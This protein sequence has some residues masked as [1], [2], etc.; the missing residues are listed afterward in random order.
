VQTLVQPQADLVARLR[1][2]GIKPPPSVV[3]TYEISKQ[4][5][6]T[7]GGQH[8]YI[9]ET[10]QPIQLTAHQRLVLNIIAG[11]HQ[12]ERLLPFYST[13]L[14]SDIKKTG[15]TA[16][17]GLYA[18][19]RAE[20]GLQKKEIQFFAND[21]E[22]SRGRGYA[23]LRLSIELHPLY[24][25]R[26]RVLLDNTGSVR[27]RIIDDFMEHVP[28]GTLVKA[29]NVDY[30][31]DAGS[32]PDLSVWTEAWGFDSKKQELLYDEMTPI[33]TK[34]RS[35][36]YVES[37]AGY[38][39]KSIVLEKLWNLATDEGQGARRLTHEDLNYE[40]P[41]PD[42]E[43]LPLWVNDEAGVF[44]YI[45]QGP[46]AKLRVPWTQGPAA[47]Q[48]YT[49]QAHTLTVEQNDRLHGNYWVTPTSAFLP[50]EWWKACKDES[51]PS[52]LPYREPVHMLVC[53]ALDE[54]IKVPDP[55]Q[56]GVLLDVP[57]WTQYIHPYNWR[58]TGAPA[59]SIVC[60]ADASVSGDCTAF[61]G[62]TRHPQRYQ[63][64]AL[65][66]SYKWDPPRGGKLD[67]GT[68]PHPTT[69][70][71]LA[72][73]I[74]TTCMMYNVVELAYDEWQL[75]HLMTEIKVYMQLAWCRPFSQSTA[76]DIADKQLYDL[77]KSRRIAYNYLVDLLDEHIKNAAK[78]QRSD[79]NTKLHIIKSKEDA[80]IDLVVSLSM[81]CAECLRLDV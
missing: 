2:A 37:Y 40:W 67:Y 20:H 77:V 7:F 79:E 35:Q 5:I 58:L 42:E 19:W 30:R 47:D 6:S 57:A 33:L 23:A 70:L 64:V 55:R 63:D 60:S 12:Y 8:F 1:A 3:A 16:L 14:W 22:Q 59:T 45:S 28:T 73:Q 71:S 51:L 52:L 10:N 78:K 75:H 29:V 17:S 15:K 56:P 72:Q 26:K 27:W 76:R 68:T 36:R 11:E 48:Y 66:F 44:A 81:A 31:G 54:T 39:G 34:T 46:M 80:K 53:P 41:W 49:E 69:D 50:L 65:R 4:P 21:E 38:T 43:E 74:I 61:T 32:A 24:D 13:V 62:V 25:K 18:R 9:P